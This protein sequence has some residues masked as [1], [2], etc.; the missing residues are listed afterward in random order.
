MLAA[1]YL[2]LAHA[3]KFLTSTFGARSTGKRSD[4]LHRIPFIALFTTLMIIG[5]HGTSALKI[6]MIITLNYFIGKR[7]ATLQYG[8]IIIWVF[9]LV[10]LFANE[11]Q[12][13]YRFASLHSGLNYLVCLLPLEY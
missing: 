3:Y 8:P 12:D 10:V 7:V 9:N 2:G 4:N 6:L 5:L 13:G 1:V 11:L